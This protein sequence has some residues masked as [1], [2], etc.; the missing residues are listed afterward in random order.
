MPDI[1]QIRQFIAVAEEKHFRL[2]S[3]RLNMTQPPLSLSIKKLEE[4][5]GTRLLDR[6]NKTVSLTPAGEVFLSGAYELVN[7]LEQVSN[8]TRRA[9]QGLTGRLT[10]GFVGSAIYDALPTIVRRFRSDFPDVELELEELSTIDQLNAISNGHIDAGLLRPPVT[11][12]SLFQITTV[13]TEKLIAV[14]PEGHALAARNAIPLSELANDGFILFP[15]KTSPNLHALVLQAC[16]NAGFTPRISQTAHQIQTQIS[17]VSAGL[18]VALVPECARQAVHKGVI[19]KDIKG[20][21][22]AIKTQMAVACRQIPGSSLLGAFIE[23]CQGLEKSKTG[24]QT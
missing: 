13:R 2:A 4:D 20:S 12:S 16:H 9:A 10:I 1:R 23:R 21:A 3:E 5:L 11:G 18:G 6:N 22:Q 24:D 8:D 19:Y 17:L 7:K 14:M 15:L